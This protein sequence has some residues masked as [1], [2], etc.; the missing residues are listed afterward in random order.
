MKYISASEI[1]PE[2]LIH[3]IQKYIQ[4]K[5]LYQHLKGIERNGGKIRGNVSF[6]KNETQ[7]F[8]SFFNRVK[9]W[10]ALGVLTVYLMKVLKKLF[11]IE[12][13]KKRQARVK[14]YVSFFM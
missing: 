6:F 2:D 11:I 5:T 10:I 13:Y 14:Q 3:E 1:L 12:K 4:G 7:R 8:G 9:I